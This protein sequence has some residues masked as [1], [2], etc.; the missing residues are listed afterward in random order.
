ML[1]PPRLLPVLCTL[2]PLAKSPSGQPSKQNVAPFSPDGAVSP[3][4]PSCLYNTIA[5]HS[6]CYAITCACSAVA[7]LAA[8]VAYTPSSIRPV[9]STAGIIY[10]AAIVSPTTADT[11]TNNIDDN[12]ATDWS[13]PLL[14]P[15]L[16]NCKQQICTP[17][18]ITYFFIE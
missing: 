2:T 13:M 15:E 4:Y 10:A 5:C 7:C 6:S 8:A 3:L 9:T 16:Q 12:T 1:L 11:Y 18:P 14:R 17:C